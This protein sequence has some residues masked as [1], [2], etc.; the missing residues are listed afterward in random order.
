MNSSLAKS[1]RKQWLRKRNLRRARRFAADLTTGA[2]PVFILTNPADLHFAPLAVSTRSKS[3]TQIFV[4]NGLSDSD[5]AWLRERCPGIPILRLSASLSG[6]A[7]SYL[8]HGELVDLLAL[9]LDEPFFIQDAD[10]FVLDPAFFEHLRIPDETEYAAG[11]YWKDCPDWNHLLPDTFLV[12]INSSSLRRVR[13]DYQV[14]ASITVTPPK[15]AASKLAETGV[16]GTWFPEQTHDKHYFDTLQL[17]WILATLDG[18]KFGKIEG[19]SERVHHVGGTSYLAADPS[20]DLSHWDWWPLNTV[21]T[22]M[23]VLEYPGSQ[24]LRARFRHLYE[25]FGDANEIESQYPKFLE[26]SRCA[27]TLDVL[28]RVG[29]RNK[30]PLCAP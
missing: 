21:Y 30:A 25:N 8:P 16:L 20:M 1:L 23:R 22:T 17:S 18:E 15:R 10:C 5:S 12:G 7:A 13:N 29:E 3:H 14:D 6:N 24:P 28:S 2:P 27:A 26:S 19:Q 11:P 4:G 9:S